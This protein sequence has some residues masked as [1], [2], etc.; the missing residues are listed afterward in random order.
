MVA[1]GGLERPEAPSSIH[2]KI[3]VIVIQAAELKYFVFHPPMKCLRL[4]TMPRKKLQ[5][6]HRK[7][8]QAYSKVRDSCIVAAGL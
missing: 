8:D 2:C 6:C 7:A 4:S 5:Q 1:G 3:L